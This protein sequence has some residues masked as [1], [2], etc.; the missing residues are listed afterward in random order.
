MLFNFSKLNDRHFAP[1]GSARLFF[2]EPLRRAAKS[3]RPFAVDPRLNVNEETHYWNDRLRIRISANSGGT[4]RSKENVLSGLLDFEKD[5]TDF[6]TTRHF[7]GIPDEAG[8]PGLT[9]L[10]R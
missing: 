4:I 3:S 2:L 10:R 5:L 1:S 7:K 9:P 6:A 8:A